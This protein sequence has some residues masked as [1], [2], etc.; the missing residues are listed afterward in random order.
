MKSQPSLSP[1]ETK[2]ESVGMC[3]IE[4][5]WFRSE[6]EHADYCLRII[7]S[8]IVLMFSNPSSAFPTAPVFVPCSMTL[9][10]QSGEKLGAHLLNL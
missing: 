5:L 6:P 4:F 2:P 7:S 10:L 8:H 1:G 3:K 9:G